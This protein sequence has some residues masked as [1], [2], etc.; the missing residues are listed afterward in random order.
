[1]NRRSL[2]PARLALEVD[3]PIHA[4][5]E[6]KTQRDDGLSLSNRLEVLFQ[7]QSIPY[8]VLPS[9]DI[10]SPEV[11]SVLKGSSESVFIYSGFGGAIL[12]DDVLDLGKKFLH[13]HGGYLPNFKG[14]TT[15]YFSLLGERRVGAS[16]IFLTKE[17]DGG[18]NLASPMVRLT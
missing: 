10:N 2:S 14:S 17:I 1:M 5:V 6:E 15:N 13:V 7:E 3:G 18:T 16:A 8:Q 11:V 12:R 4:V 9:S